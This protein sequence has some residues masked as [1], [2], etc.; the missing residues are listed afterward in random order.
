MR[1]T[2]DLLADAKIILET[3][4][5]ILHIGKRLPGQNSGMNVAS[6]FMRKIAGWVLSVAEKDN[7]FKAEVCPG[8]CFACAGMPVKLHCIPYEVRLCSASILSQAVPVQPAVTGFNPSGD[9]S[10]FQPG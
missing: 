1:R 10:I 3:I 5:K 6:R 7:H 9:V 2:P 8:R 4:L